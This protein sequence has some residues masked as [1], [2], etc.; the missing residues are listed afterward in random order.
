MEFSHWSH[1]NE[2][3]IN[4]AEGSSSSFIEG[5]IWY[6]KDQDLMYKPDTL[7]V[8]YKME[9]LG[10]EAVSEVNKNILEELHQHCV[11]IDIDWKS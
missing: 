5:T 6:W 7:A 4:F 8:L 11:I 2:F 9:D 1:Q 10:A 3:W